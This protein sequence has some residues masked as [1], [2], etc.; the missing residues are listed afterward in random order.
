MGCSTHHSQDLNPNLL[1]QRI[2]PTSTLPSPRIRNRNLHRYR[3]RDL[4]R[5]DFSP[6]PASA[7]VVGLEPGQHVCYRQS[8]IPVHG[9]DP[10]CCDGRGHRGTSAARCLEVANFQ[11]RENLFDGHFFAWFVVGQI[12]LG[13]AMIW[14]T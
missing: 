4:Y 5:R 10:Q 7:I 1:R 11:A 12:A 9:L 2:R 14:L 13:R 3:N 6:L 8:C